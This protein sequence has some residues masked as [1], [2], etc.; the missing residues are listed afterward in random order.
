MLLGDTCTRACGFCAVKTGKP[1]TPDDDEPRRIV[2]AVDRLKLQYIVL[3]SVNR[4]DLDDGG[5]AIFAGTIEGLRSRRP[6]IG[7]ELLTPDFYR[8]QGNAIEVITT[9]LA[10]GDVRQLVWGHNI[11]TVPRLYRQVR[12]GS[13]YARSLE[14]LRRIANLDEIEAKTALILGLGETEEELLSVMH[15]LRERGVQR[16]ALGQ[17]LRPTHRHLPVQA[18]IH[19]EAFIKYGQQARDLGFTWVKAGPLVR[20]SYHAE[21]VQSGK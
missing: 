8:C 11:E 9:A 5:A 20:S 19:P 18:Y 4:D 21:E 17:Y 1:A 2:E 10:A 6:S 16:L 13:D 3:T 15:D 12:R 14:L 7:I